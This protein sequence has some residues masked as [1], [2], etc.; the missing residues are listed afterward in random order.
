M[1]GCVIMPNIGQETFNKL[2]K[3]L[4]YDLAREV[5]LK[6]ISPKFKTDFK[7]TLSLDAEGVP[8]YESIMRNK[9]MKELIGISKINKIV[10][11]DFPMLNDTIDNY[12]IAV[13][14][15]YDFNTTSIYRDDYVAVVD[16]TNDK[17]QVKILSK[18]KENVDKFTEQYN[19]NKINNRL[20]QIFEPL[21]IT[22]GMLTEAEQNAGRIG[23]IDFSK[24]RNIAVDSSSMIRVSNNMEGA[25]AISEEYSHLLI[26]VFKDNPL[27]KRAIASLSKNEQALKEILGNHYQ[28]VYDFYQGNISLV[29]EEA[30]GQILQ[31]NLIKNT[32]LHKTVQPNLFTRLINYIKDKFKNYNVEDVDQLIE[33]VDSSMNKLSEDILKGYKNID[34]KSIQD[35]QTE[36]QFNAL[37]D[38]I[39]RNIKILQDSKAVELKRYKISKDKNKDYSEA[40]IKELD[41]YSQKDADTAL[42]ILKYAYN[43][44]SEL[45]YIQMEFREAY[46]KT[47]KE[48]FTF[49]KKVNI[50]ITS[51]ADFINTINNVIIEEENE[52]DNMF[53]QDVEINGQTVNMQAVIKELSNMQ[54]ELSGR[55]NKAAF[56][57]FAEFLKPFIGEEIVVPFGKFAGTTMSV[58]KLLKKANRDISFMEKW[59]DSMADS[60]DIILQGIDSAVKNAKDKARLKAI[61]I[62]RRIQD[63][64]QKAEKLGITTFEWVFE[65]YDNGDFTGG[66]ISEVNSAQYQRDKENM[67][68]GLEDKYGSN[69][70]GQNALDYIAERDAWYDKY[71]ASRYN[72]EIPKKGEYL[73]LK[74]LNLSED[75]KQILKEFLDLKQELDKKYP[76]NRTQTLKAI[77][78]RKSGTQRFLDSLSSPSKIFEN[79]KENLKDTFLERSD[80]DQ[81]FGNTNQNF[82]NFE[83]NEFMSL[84]I[85]FTNL[86]E[87]PN[88]LSTDIFSTL[89]AYAYSTTLYE[90]MDQIIDP[91]EIG[92]IILDQRDTVATEGNKIVEEIFNVLGEKI[93]KTV[94]QGGV[95]NWK[96]RLDDFYKSQIYNRYIK[97][98]GTILGTQVSVSKSANFL[99]KVTS[100]ARIGFN[101]LTQIA[102]VGNGVAMQNIEAASRE[103]FTAKDL[104]KAD[105]IYSSNMPS[106]MSELGARSKTNKLSLFDEL[107]NIK[108]DFDEKSK[109]TQKKNLLERIFGVNIAFI[110]Q[111]A[112]DHWLYNRTALAMANSYK[113]IVPG[114]GEM[115]LWEAL[116]VINSFENNDKIKELTLPEGTTDLEGRVIT[117]EDLTD[118]GRKINAVNQSLFGIYN[119]EDANA[120]NRIA[121]GRLLLQFRKYMRPL[122][123]K[124]F[125]S[126]KHNNQLKQFQEGYYITA[127][128]IINELIRGKVQL[129]SLLSSTFSKENT[130]NLKDHEISNIRRTLFEIAQFACIWM[131]ANMLEW[132]DDKDRPWALKLAEYSAKRLS[133]ELGMFTPS[134]TMI[135]ENLKT[136][137]NPLACLS[138]ITD[139]INLIS[140]AIDPSDYTDELQSGPYKGMSTLEKHL[141]KAPIPGIMQYRQIDRFIG[142]ID[143]SISYYARPN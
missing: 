89:N 96:S 9:Y 99:M 72:P 135:D 113:V 120:A 77:Q 127:F 68:K 21:G 46:K 22:I 66:Y 137:K 104:L 65:Q 102:N 25:K 132:P 114:K 116:E 6:S 56:S 71:S 59:V 36:L 82:T 129:G 139:T 69:P 1:S 106:F 5:F 92:K 118:F 88:E 91:L 86:L 58:E 12:N 136:V 107:F 100:V 3:D 125:R 30:L 85:L 117:E 43:A 34:K 110:G 140:S 131:V 27:V 142:E 41:Y 4:G 10:Q 17:I 138:T 49:L 61:K 124:R 28:E 52:E 50:Y 123:N 105:G 2:K 122:Y 24:A 128:R 70:T 14:K 48:M 121:M 35:L 103:Y 130:S 111:S 33:Q 90:E 26:R 87:N 134:L 101:A 93:S 8:S 29:A 143:T 40:I 64:R 20:T 73:N 23:H 95:F 57:S 81:L 16:Y 51:Y 75:Q 80:D 44:L 19:V 55:F 119:E 115:S 39:E 133:H 126:T 15:A 37:S 38:R 141:L 18:T 11:K 53:L 76:P 83:G 31:D 109:R 63:L 7:G 98:E 78:I 62:F 94:H 60:S 67:L 47:P 108:Q 32:N 79:I 112:G 74:Y 54:T 45:R 42:G 97:N 13:Q 84:P